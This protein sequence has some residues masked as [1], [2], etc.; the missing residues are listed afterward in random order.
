MDIKFCPENINYDPNNRIYWLKI[1]ASSDKDA[2]SATIWVCASDNY[3]EDHFQVQE[4]INQIILNL[5]LKS[6]LG[7]LKQKYRSVSLGNGPY[8]EVFSMT[9][10]G[11]NPELSFLKEKAKI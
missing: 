9:R 11:F 2:Q 6:V 4:C 10:T 3:I 8:F 5:W 7:Y 1:N